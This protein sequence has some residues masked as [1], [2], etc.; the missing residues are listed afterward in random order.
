MST[1]HARGAPVSAIHHS[2]LF[3]ASRHALGFARYPFSTDRYLTNREEQIISFASEDLY[4]PAT[5]P[6]Y[7]AGQIGVDIKNRTF[8]S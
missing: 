1:R 5:K 3:V 8:G 2:R 4:V 7:L 6:L